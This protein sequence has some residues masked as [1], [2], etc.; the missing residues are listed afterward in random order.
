MFRGLVCSGP[1]WSFFLAAPQASAANLSS[2][3]V[4]PTSVVGGMANATGTVTLDVV[5]PAGDVVVGLSS[6]SAYASVPL[7][8][9]VLAGSRTATFTVTT[10]APIT[11]QTATITA[12]YNAVNKTANLTVTTLISSVTLARS[13]V[14]GGMAVTG[15]V[16]LYAP[17]PSGGTVVTLTSSATTRATVPSS[18]T[19]PAGATLATF[20]AAT[21]TAATTGSSTITASNAGTNKTVALTTSASAIPYTLT[22]NP[23]TVFGSSTSTGTVTL[24]GAAPTGGTTVTLTSSNTALA[25]VPSSIVVSGGAPSATF[26]VSTLTGSGSA[27]ITA[28]AGGTSRTA[29]QTIAAALQPFSVTLDRTS[30]TRGQSPIA[31]VQLNGQAPTGGASVTLTSSR[32]SRPRP[33]PSRTTSTP[34]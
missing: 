4:A 29:T 10:S 27:V 6:N 14:V 13:S 25:T 5:A 3:S 22:L 19:V 15:A 17:A 1:S 33:W 23:T 12:T 26:T 24:N 21:L 28:A 20:V 2:V 9:T 16:N 11:N 30:V 18:V 31:T 32:H 7:S 34:R 8:V